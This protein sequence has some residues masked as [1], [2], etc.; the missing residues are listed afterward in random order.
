MALLSTVRHEVLVTTRS[1]PEDESRLRE[2]LQGESDNRAYSS[3]QAAI[4]NVSSGD[5]EEAIRNLWQLVDSTADGNCTAEVLLLDGWRHRTFIQCV[6]RARAR[7]GGEP[8]RR[9]SRVAR[10]LDR[11]RPSVQAQLR[12]CQCWRW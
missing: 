12:R 10:Y 11:A 9:I 4:R 8:R 7:S 3:L 2:L 1:A 6:D 5:V